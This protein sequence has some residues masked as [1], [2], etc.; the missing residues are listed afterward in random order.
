MTRIRGV[1]PWLRAIAVGL[2]LGISV[3]TAQ[4]DFILEGAFDWRDVDGEDFTTP[5]RDQG[6]AGT[7]WAFAAVGA[8][9]SKLEI[10][11][12]NPNWN[13]DLSEQHL[14]SDPNG[15]GDRAGGWPA[16]SL[17]FFV[18]TGVVTEAELP[19]AGLDSPTGWPLEPGWEDRTCRITS[20]LPNSGVTTNLLKAMLQ[21]HGPL[22]VNLDMDY[23]FWFPGEA[24]PEIPVINTI[25]HSVVVVGFVDDPSL[26]AGG[27]WI[28][29]NSW[30]IGWGDD[31]Y[32]YSL[33]G[34]SE[35]HGQ[36]RAIDGAAYPV[37]EPATLVL[38]LIGSA[39]LLRRRRAA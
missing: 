26:T 15:G 1:N 33:Y 39:A 28:I 32:G 23:D 4:A 22:I 20:Y 31:G 12:N 13:P 14:V 2:L 10:S 5:V 25:N 38:S 34:F 37:P 16:L 11:A 35:R 29:K 30:G 36:F 21:L 9:E 24:E 19:Y 6:P 17:Q 7:C 3:C 18:D 8:L 27:Y